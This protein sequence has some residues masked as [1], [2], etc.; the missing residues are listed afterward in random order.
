M[1]R[2]ETTLADTPESTAPDRVPALARDGA[3]EAE[4]HELAQETGDWVE[5]LQDLLRASGSDRVREI[6]SVLQ[7]HAQR[8]GI[9]LPV[10]SRTPFI[11]SIAAEHDL[12]YPGDRE[13]ERRI[14]SI[15]RWNAMAMVTRA[16][17][18]EAGIGGHISTYASAATLLEVGFQHFFRGKD[19]PCGGDLVYF[20]GHASP[21]IYARS[22]LEGRIGVEKLRAF[23][24]EL[25]EGGGLSS[26][27]HP[28]LMPEYW[29]FPT[30]SMG[31][32][33]IQALYRAR[34]LRYL[35][36]RGLKE[37]TDQKVWCFIGDGETDEPETLGAISMAAR[38]SLDN[39]IFV[40]NCNLQ[41]LDGP[42]R[43]NTKIIQ[44]LEAVFRGV[45]WNVLKVIWGEDWDPLL[46]QDD[47]G[48]LVQRMGE[49][50]D[51]EY[52][53][54]RVRGGA[55]VRDHF[56]GADPRLSK[57]VEH[58]DDAALM[59]L[60]IGGH[61]PVKVHTAYRAAMEHRGAPTVILAHTIKGYG[62]GEAGE[63]KN[64][65]HQQK[66]LNEEELLQ[67]RDRFCIPISDED[68]GGAPFYR[69]P[70]DSPEIE[71]LLERRRELG[72]FLP[73]RRAHR[74]A[75]TM[76]EPELYA[77][78]HAGTD[79]LEVSTTMA[80]V[81]MLSKLLRDD[82]IGARIVP[83]VPDE[84]RTFGMESLFRQVGIYS[85]MGQRY[86]PVDSDNLLYY[87][88]EVK[89]QILEEG[90]NEAG[91]MSSFI[92]AGTSHTMHGVATI[93]MYFFY[94]M[95]GFQRVM[96][97]IWA[98]SD[99][100]ARGFLMGATAG[101]TTLNGEGLQHQDG[102]SH[103][104]A[105]AVPNVE[106]YDPAY[107]YEVAVIIEE[108]MRRMYR[109]DEDLIYYITLG[110]ENYPQPKM[111]EGSREGILR[112]L[113]RVHTSALPGPRMQL[114]GSG[115]ILRECRAGALILAER[116]GIAADVWSATSWKRLREDASDVERWNLRHPGEPRRA[117]HLARSFA[118]LPGPF[119]AATDYVTAIPDSIARWLPGPLTSLG[120]D[121]FGRS[122]SRAA[123]RD[124]FE[125]DARHIAWAAV[126]ALAREGTV[127]AELVPRA[128]S[129]LEIDPEKTNP[130][131]A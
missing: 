127:D 111:P 116:F 4:L 23:R 90:I 74:A 64:V 1:V 122:D 71:Y 5:S 56:W 40:V 6:L 98:A 46:A 14:K 70:D 52:Q 85:G 28:W 11:N 17:R 112:G 107:A 131:L 54:Y 124:H 88:Q 91:A 121:G 32:G 19:H 2:R 118:G 120:T 119:V 100:R 3:R 41:R 47:D 104:L 73:E 37:P 66:K 60:R 83:I 106:A 101:R 93:P 31:L 48:R 24:R 21:G 36:N 75:L 114:L 27:P 55:Y 96:D 18:E 65:T 69:P 16:N 113:H 49:V 78:F 82:E 125:V 8:E 81:R 102:H 26:Y 58:L 30:V 115:S 61:D 99:S 33:P 110:N 13:L 128:M 109:D 95:F 105:L 84:A 89:G 126:S 59:R 123:L 42:V 129:E 117:S 80:A 10:T 39:L 130:R 97:L 94:S 63:G 57:M 68:A 53:N 79:E 103:L 77:E 108:G 51:G 87:R 22:Y 76:P 7:R 35:E 20:Q 15:I 50:V 45:G 34:F 72:G 38:K 44:E 62:L 67:F 29:E 12:P 86:Q 92:A 43:G 25:R 9:I